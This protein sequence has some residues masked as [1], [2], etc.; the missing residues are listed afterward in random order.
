MKS[1]HGKS[2]SVPFNRCYWVVPEKLMAG[3]YP[4]APDEKEARR[5]LTGLLDH[6]I[7]HMLNLMETDEVNHS[8]NAFLPYEPIMRAIARSKCMEVS[9]NRMPIRDLSVPTVAEMVGI[10]NHIDRKIKANIPVF[11]HCWGGRGRTGTV[12]GC[13]LAMHGYAPDGNIS[14]MFQTLRMNAADFQM[15]SPETGEQIDMV[16]SWLK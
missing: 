8:G 6:G 13:Y 9:F 12:V 1:F 5:K 15:P 4:G 14:R 3:C 11:I 7:R 16:L 10:L 2:L